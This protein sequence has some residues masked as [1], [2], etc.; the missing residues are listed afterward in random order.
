MTTT[1]NDQ[2]E[3]SQLDWHISPLGDTFTEIAP[4]IELVLPIAATASDDGFTWTLHVDLVDG[5]LACTTLAVERIADAPVTSALLRPFAIQRHVNEIVASS[6]ESF[7]TVD[8]ELVDTS[9]APDDFPATGPTD[10]NLRYVARRYRIAELSGERPTKTLEALGLPRR[11]A[12]SW[13][14]KARTKGLL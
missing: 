9:H 7:E 12:Q 3:P 8:G 6:I 4:G 5:R 1:R 10:A 13:I 11:T 14:S 2:H